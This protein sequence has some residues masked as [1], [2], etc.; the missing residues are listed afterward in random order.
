MKISML[1]AAAAVLLSATSALSFEG[2]TLV[3]EDEAYV[4][5]VASEPQ[6]EADPTYNEDYLPEYNPY[7][8]SYENYYAPTRN[9]KVPARS[10]ECWMYVDT[11]NL[12]N[13]LTAP[14]KVE[15]ILS[16]LQA[17]EKKAGTCPAKASELGKEKCRV[18]LEALETLKYIYG[19]L[20][21]DSEKTNNT[22]CGIQTP[23]QVE[24]NIW[25]KQSK[26]A[27]ERLKALGGHWPCYSNLSTR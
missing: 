27:C 20:L 3:L 4:G 13:R 6:A 11:Y 9:P 5:D 7:D 10:G 1:A 22:S 2:E 26:Y 24:N 18:L 8:P 21:K 15:N 23:A 25:V 17:D 12:I 14:Q 19:N 16:I